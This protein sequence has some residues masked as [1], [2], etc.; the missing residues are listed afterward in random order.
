M[1]KPAK[2]RGFSY[3]QEAFLLLFQ[4][5]EMTHMEATDNG[6]FFNIFSLQTQSEL[7]RCSN[8]ANMSATGA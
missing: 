4:A 3:H 1:G 2:S 5:A 8:I 7:H 6:Y